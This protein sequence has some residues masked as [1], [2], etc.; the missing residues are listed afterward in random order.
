MNLFLKLF[1]IGGK[2][3]LFVVKKI[4]YIVYEMNKRYGIVGFVIY[5]NIGYFECLIYLY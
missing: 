5:E 2:F 3:G 4:V 1:L